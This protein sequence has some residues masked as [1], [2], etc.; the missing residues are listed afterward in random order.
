MYVQAPPAGQAKQILLPCHKGPIHHV[1]NSLPNDYSV[2]ID[3]E[4]T[5]LQSSKPKSTKRTRY[6]GYL[7]VTRETSSRC[8]QSYNI[9]PC[10]SLACRPFRSCRDANQNLQSA[11]NGALHCTAFKNAPPHTAAAP[12][13]NQATTCK[14]WKP[15]HP[16]L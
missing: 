11:S 16:A 13:G 6:L 10:Q 15:R 3:A 7:S 5:V 8:Q 2:S 1:V 14:H 9:N 12:G 4:T